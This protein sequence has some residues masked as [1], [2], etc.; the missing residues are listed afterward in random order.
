MVKSSGTLCFLISAFCLVLFINCL[1]TVVDPDAFN[2]D[3]DVIVDTATVK[4]VITQVRDKR[5]YVPLPG[6]VVTVFGLKT[7]ITDSSGIAYFDSVKPGNYS[8]LCEKTGYEA[9]VSTLTI[10]AGGELQRDGKNLD[11]TQI[12]TMPRKGV[13]VTGKVYYQ[14]EAQKKGAE[15]AT[16]ECRIGSTSQPLYNQP[17]KTAFVSVDEFKF[18]DLPESEYYYITVKPFTVGTKKYQYSSSIT[19][20]GNSAGETVYCSPIILTSSSGN[21][22]MALSHN[23]QTLKAGDSIIVNFSEAVDTSGITADSIYVSQTYLILTRLLWSN[24]NKKLA[25]V[26]FDGKWVTGSNYRL[27]IRRLKSVAGNIFSNGEFQPYYFSVGSGVLDNVQYIKI[28]NVDYTNDTFVDYSSSSIM[29]NWSKI[30]NATSYELY[31][32]PGPDSFWVNIT[33]VYDTT[34]TVSTTN[35]FR[36]GN[37]VKYLVLGKNASGK[38]SFE[39]APVLSVKDNRKPRIYTSSY[40]Y[41][42]NNGLGSVPKTVS[43][44]V[45]YIPEPMDTTIDPVLSTV[46]ASYAGMGDTAYCIPASACQWIWTGLNSAKIDVMI[47]AGKNGGYDSL[48]VDFTPTKDYAGNEA[49]T[50]GVYGMA[51]YHTRD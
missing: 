45:T 10:L 39:T 42:F 13:M 4:K 17:I 47:D 41:G 8:V 49:D 19:L 25:I 3:D 20:Q 22:F 6:A 34:G 24:G 30:N 48:K 44:S 32:K 33:T 16:V 31:C 29:F 21:S 9:V 51:T 40:A 1:D 36:F 18:N 12:I 7:G 27:Y 15:G 23:C 26:P 38:S 50:A 11:V 46:E 43:L 37:I 5:T 28:K 14:D 2:D 35:K